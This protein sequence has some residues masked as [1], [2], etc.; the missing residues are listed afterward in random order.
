MS[1][2]VYSSALTLAA[3]GAAARGLVVILAFV[4]TFLNRRQFV[5]FRFGWIECL[6]SVEPLLLLAMAGGSLKAFALR[7]LHRSAE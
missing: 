2:L 1:T 7:I 3:I 4:R 6:V 5:S